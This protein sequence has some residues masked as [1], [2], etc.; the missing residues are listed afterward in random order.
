MINWFFD[1]IQG[2]V[3]KNYPSKLLLTTLQCFLS[4]IQSFIIAI[5]M[6]RDPSQWKLGWN[7]RLLAVAY[8]VS[9]ALYIICIFFANEFSSFLYSVDFLR[10][11]L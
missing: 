1:F 2:N 5:A 9:T 10:T 11:K 8:C 6:E 4:S 3:M 7:V